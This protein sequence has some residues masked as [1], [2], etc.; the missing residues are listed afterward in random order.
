[1][2]FGLCPH[3]HMLISNQIEKDSMFA[4]K[5]YTEYDGSSNSRKIRK[6]LKVIC[7][8]NSSVFKG[9]N[10]ESTIIN[11]TPISTLK[12]DGSCIYLC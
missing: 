1:M 7:M 11:E 4:M 5:L 6:S 8:S 10:L 12:Q 3:Y 9:G 2:S